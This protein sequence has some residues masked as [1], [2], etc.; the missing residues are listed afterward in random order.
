MT[1]PT[2]T[3]PGGEAE[4]NDDVAL[5]S[6][7][8]AHAPPI[9]EPGEK[10]ENQLM[11]TIASESP[12]RSTQQKSRSSQVRRSVAAL[13]G[14]GVGALAIGIQLR[15]WF[16]PPVTSAELAQLESFMV[17]DWNAIVDHEAVREWDWL[18]S[19]SQDL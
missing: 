6:F 18:E 14:L 5:V 12:R 7:L 1:K 15:Q 17:N 10:L 11:E 8:K 16:S 19:R 2:V 9:S 4:P 13:L 3:P